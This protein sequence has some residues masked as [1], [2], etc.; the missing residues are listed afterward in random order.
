MQLSKINIKEF[1]F[2]IILVVLGVILI[3]LFSPF[4]NIILLALV[5]VQ[6]FYPLYKRIQKA[7][8]NT[9]LSSVLT[10]LS[11]FL[12]VVIPI[13]I[14]TGLAIAEVTHLVSTVTSTKTS[15][16]VITQQA[17]NENKSKEEVAIETW[18]QPSLQ[19]LNT[20]LVDSKLVPKDS[21]PIT[22]QKIISFVLGN[23]RDFFVPITTEVISG[24]VN[25]LFSLFILTLTLIYLF[26]AYE[27]LPQ[28]IKRIS[29]LDD[30]LDDLLVSKFTETSQAV[31]KG[32]FLVAIAQATA[33]I[34]A[35]VLMNVGSPVLL[36]LIMVILS[37]VPIGSGLIFIPV[38]IIMAAT[39]NATNGIFLIIYGV[40]I[41]NVID[42]LLRPY[43]MK[44]TVQLHPMVIIFSVIG[45][46]SAFGPLGILY[47][48]LIAVF[49]TA[50]MDVYNQHFMTQSSANEAVSEG[51]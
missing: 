32:T 33:V 15:D 24:S 21:P 44:E 11:A 23:I 4:L 48:P 41:I 12:V 29:P 37:I 20:F 3:R 36:W 18:L 39:G 10:T 19:Q 43:L 9:G 6:L 50:L 22:V 45:G 42:A 46:I 35:M 30:K 8:N 5:I 16:S 17:I 25:I 47:G 31:I 49:F 7:L 13:I 40:V 26:P 2:L 34:A 1:F 51:A 38:G 27:R 14:I 28:F